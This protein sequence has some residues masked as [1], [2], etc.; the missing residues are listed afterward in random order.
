MALVIG[1]IIIVA[2]GM[3]GLGIGYILRGRCFR[4]T[5]GGEDVFGPDGELLLCDHCPKRAE[6]E[7][8]AESP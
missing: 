2:L 5:C 8:A 4:G 7:E 1:T 6:Y 3:L